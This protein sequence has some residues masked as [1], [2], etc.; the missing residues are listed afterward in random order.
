L[1]RQAHVACLFPNHFLLFLV[2]PA[3]EKD[4]LTE[5]IIPRPLRKFYLAD[6]RRF[7]PMAPLHFGS[8]QTLVPAAT[9]NC[10]K[11]I[12]GTLFNPNFV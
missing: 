11:V 10:R 7:D 9:T 12:K 4:W 2:S 5:T 3:T 6:H 8:S 1:S